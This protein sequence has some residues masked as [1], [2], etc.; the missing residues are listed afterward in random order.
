LLEAT[1]AMEDYTLLEARDG[2]EAWEILLTQRPG[3]AILDHRMPGRTGLELV[4]AVRAQPSLAG[5]RLIL[6]TGSS[7]TDDVA[8]GMA[9][10]VDAYLTKPFSPLQLLGTVHG[11]LARNRPDVRATDRLYWALVE[12]VP[13]A[14]LVLDQQHNRFVV[15]NTAAER[16]FGRSRV[17]MLQQ[18]PEDVTL[19]E[20]RPRLAA[21][22]AELEAR[23]TFE[24]TWRVVRGDGTVVSADV[25]VT[26]VEVDG[27][28]LL[29]AAFRDVPNVRPEK[30][31]A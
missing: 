30:S 26:R 1:L 18:R 19:W 29:Q 20:D 5:T 15:A 2:N 7:D 22:L 17:E 14:L 16:L 11:L 3:L 28:V 4:R 13:L 21:A 31:A 6:L 24:G 25:Q 27:R 23:G 9:A 12:H 10:G 8:A